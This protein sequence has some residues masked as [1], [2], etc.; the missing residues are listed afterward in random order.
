[1]AEETGSGEKGK[2]TQEDRLAEIEE[3][4]R[5][6]LQAEEERIAV[7]EKRADA[8]KKK[9]EEI[10]A[11]MA[12]KKV[13]EEE[14]RL[15]EGLSDEGK[16]RLATIEASVKEKQ[17]R[18]DRIRRLERISSMEEKA[19]QSGLAKTAQQVTYVRARGARIGSVMFYLFLVIGI[20]FLIPDIIRNLAE[21]NLLEGYK[22]WL[23]E[24]MDEPL[25]TVT[26]LGLIGIVFVVVSIVILAS[27]FIIYRKR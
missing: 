7:I 10:A 3:R 14:A 5:K 17:E 16:K 8:A 12:E 20:I 26:G 18:E 9:Q 19:A 11:K 25:E 1:M 2:S 13:V 21:I 6:I 23:F 22:G 24:H 27:M 4:N 15:V